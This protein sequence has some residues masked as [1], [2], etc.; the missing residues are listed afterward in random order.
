MSF[1]PT[2]LDSIAAKSVLI[3]GGSSG[4]GLATARAFV[5]SGAYVTIADIQ[6]P[7]EDAFGDGQCRVNFS[8]CDVRDSASQAE[9]FKGAVKFAPSHALDV[10]AL[11]AAVDDSPNLVDLVK[12]SD[13][14]AI[15]VPHQLISHEKT[16]GFAEASSGGG[17]PN[18]DNLSI[19]CLDVN[20]KGIYY[21]TYL[22]LHYLQQPQA[23]PSSQ[24][25][26]TNNR[27]TKSLILLSSL[28][29]YLDDS[30]DSIYSATKYGIRGL[31]RSIRLRSYNE[32]NVRCN[33]V[34]P[35]VIR[36]P[37]TAPL[38]GFLDKSG[39]PQGKGLTFA[40]VDAAVEAVGRCAVDEKVVGRSIAVVPEGNFDLGD[41]EEGLWAGTALK[42]IVQARKDAG[43]VIV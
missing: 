30:H 26:G 19:K 21:S 4:L 39:I 41:D 1:D 34:A 8:L 9:A 27:S 24:T 23:A 13:S 25:S 3:T 38:Q 20:L 17:G 6:P 10:V 36:T 28:G 37:L 7:P 31:F 33:L 42:K 22:A 14:Q 35:W 29:G 16:A 11:F 32:L 12:A 5:A 43:D 2:N 40:T 15:N 18:L